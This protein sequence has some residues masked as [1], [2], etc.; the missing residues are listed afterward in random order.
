MKNERI[1]NLTLT[2]LFVALVVIGSRIYIGT[3]DSFRFHLGNVMCLLAS[4]I[5]SPINAGLAAG[6]G[7]MIFDLLFYPTGLACIV[8]FI[9]KFAMSF[10][11]SFIFHKV[12]NREHETVIAIV[13]GSFG[14]IVY[15]ILY[16][17]KTFIER[18]YI[19]S[20]SID[21]VMPILFAKMAASLV[22]AI[23]AIILSTLLYKLIKKIKL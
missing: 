11:A 19:M 8:T 5:L 22:N 15:I 2:A 3:H 13:A 16:G 7:S 14:E 20:M 4:F 17:I 12:N 1:K 23:I 18:R 10:V 9:T 21:V 6:L